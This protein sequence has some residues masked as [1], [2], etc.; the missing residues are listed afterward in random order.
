MKLLFVHPDLGVGG[1]ERLIVDTAL[2]AESNGHKVTILTNHYDQNHCFEDTKSLDILVKLNS[3]PR[4]ISGRFHAFM[5][6]LKMLLA[7]LWLILFSGLEFDIIIC[8]QISIPV[9]VFKWAKYKVLF[10][11]HFPDQ[12]LCVYD[13]K[14]YLK[15]FYRAPLNWLEM[16]TTGMADVILV[17]SEF[18]KNIFYQTFSQLKN[19]QIDVLYPSLNTE[20]FDS[21]L[22]E[23]GQNYKDNQDEETKKYEDSH[24]NLS[25]LKKIGDRKYV[26]LSIN[27]YERKKD[28]KLAIE[29]FNKLKNILNADNWESCHLVLAGGYDPRV[30]ENIN[31]YQELVDLAKSFDLLDHISFLRSISDKLKIHLLRRTICLIYTPTNEHFGIVPIEA[32]YCE[33]PVIAT[34]TGGPLETVKNDL[35]GFLVKS[36][37]NEFALAMEKIIIDP[38]KRFQMSQEARKHVINSFSFVAFQHNFEKILIK[39]TIEGLVKKEN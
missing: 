8:D 34:N 5:A 28:L 26:F 15:R 33:T 17:N 14:D 6:Y 1:A 4:H 31:H 13:K 21:L 24:S 3:W 38:A 37:P 30:N 27:R 20:K 11:C 29:S 22:N 16:I 9:C 2:A 12:L 32:M 25:E 10:Y 18:T 7:S 39:M 23:L 35:S 36:C 19:K